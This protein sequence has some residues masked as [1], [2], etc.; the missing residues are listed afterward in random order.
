MLEPAQIGSKDKI[1]RWFRRYE[2]SVL[3][4]LFIAGIIFIGTIFVVAGAGRAEARYAAIVID[5][6]TGKVRHAVN[7]DTRN[8]P[9]SLTKLM[10]M[11]L[12]F[13]ALDSKKLKLD[14][15][16]AVSRR[17]ANQPASRLGLRAGQSIPVRTAIK[18]LAIK[19]ANDVA[20]VVAEALGRTER[21]F[22]LLMTAKARTLGMSRTTFRNA[23]GLP[24]RGQLSTA[25]DVAKLAQKIIQRFPHYYYFFSLSAF[26]FGGNTYRTHN[27]VLTSY[28]GADG[29]KTG[30]INASGYNLVTSARRGG[31]RLIGVI[32]GG[33]SSR[34]R[35]R[36]MKRLLDRGFAQ[37]RNQQFVRVESKPDAK[38]PRRTQKTGGSNRRQ[39]SKDVWGIQVGAFYTRRPASDIAQ[40]VMNKYA[41]Y[42]KGGRIVI[43][44][45]PKRR[46]RILYR[47]RI[48]GIG[49]QGAYRACQVLERHK[50][51][52][53]ELK[54]PAKIEV[55]SR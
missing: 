9:A 12:L 43:M 45:L 30:Y 53:M 23:S 6:E 7:A 36:L 28:P 54:I 34:S 47:A 55:A 24:H 42:L 44:P 17:A 31:H 38:S 3:Q 21:R 33:N 41:S 29:M 1:G 5:A 37:R 18:A 19:S 20:A 13:E 27:K 10:T 49:K 32:F 2:R 26:R 22:A 16:L 51:Q 14:T 48:I 25:R 35:D 52:C 50:R 15:R 46:S 11:Y 39:A 8:Y 4:S 40:K